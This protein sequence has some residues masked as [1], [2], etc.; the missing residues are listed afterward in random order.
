MLKKFFVGFIVV[1]LGAVFALSAVSCGGLDE[2]SMA[3]TNTYITNII[4]S[5]TYYI[6]NDGSGGGENA[7]N[8]YVATNGSDANSGL[9]PATA[10][11]T[12]QDAIERAVDYGVTNVYVAEGVYYGNKGLYDTGG[13]NMYAGIYIMRD[14]IN[15]VGGWNSDFTTQ[16]GRSILDGDNNRIYH[17]I[18]AEG[19]TNITING[20]VI[21]NAYANSSDA[22]DGAGGGILFNN[23]N[24]SLIT[25][26][27]I[28]NNKADYY[29][30]GVHLDGIDNTINAIIANNTSGMGGAGLYMEG[31]TSNNTI[32][33][34]ICY[35]S[36][37]G[38]LLYSSYSTINA[39]IYNNTSSGI[40]GGGK[41]NT[42][43]GSIY[44]NSSGGMS[45]HYAYNNNISSSI[46]NNT[47]SYSGGGVSLD[48]CTN[49]TFS[50]YI[51]NNTAGNGFVGGGV[52]FGN[53]ATNNIFTAS[54]VIRWNTVTGGSAGD[55]GGVYN[56]GGAGTQITNAGFTISDNSPDDWADQ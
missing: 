20:F 44:S 45:M 19:V 11:L 52:Y 10:M 54:C 21:K 23:V 51:T 6:T 8:M 28:S 48:T 34:S 13:F 9:S 39:S 46:Y 12:I 24:Y 55:G 47:C 49:N 22:I 38:I 56:S 15:L 18:T 1:V 50:G 36:G 4:T 33:G 41:F 53:N 14:N 2:G 29:G 37:D 30:G 27:I 26:C 17:V 3:I 16:T 43:S 32:N 42:I 40:A 25:N 5:N 31:T 35:N 7:S